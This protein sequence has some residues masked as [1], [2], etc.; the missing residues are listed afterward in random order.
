MREPE[1]ADRERVVRLRHLVAAQCCAQEAQ[2]VADSRVRCVVLEPVPIAND[3]ARRR[4]DAQR[5]AAE[6]DG[7]ERRRRLGDQRRAPM[8]TGTIA[9]PKR[10][11]GPLAGQHQRRERVRPVDLGGPHVG[12]A[13]VRQGGDEITLLRHGQAVQGNGQAV[14]LHGRPSISHRLAEVNPADAP[15]LVLV[16]DFGAQ[17]AQLIARR[18]REARVYSEIVPHTMPVEDML[19]RKPKAI[20]LSGG[21]RRCTHLA[22]KRGPGAVRRSRTDARHLLRLPGDGA[23]ARRHRGSHRTR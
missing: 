5:D 19:A 6:S 12:P 20:I 9:V 22:R 15:D 14:A 17:Y 4:P 21:P 7:C 18:V 13:Q 16:V 23:H 10:S 3:D 1:A 8:W 2:G 11:A